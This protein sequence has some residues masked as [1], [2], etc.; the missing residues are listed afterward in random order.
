MRSPLPKV[1]AA[2][3]STVSSSTDLPA[4]KLRPNTVSGQEIVV[5][6]QHR[7]QMTGRNGTLLVRLIR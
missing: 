1:G 6:P 2:H 7:Q 3:D 4:E 5:H